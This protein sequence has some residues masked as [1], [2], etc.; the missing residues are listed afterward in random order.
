MAAA[1]VSKNR[2]GLRYPRLVVKLGTNLLTGGTDCLDTPTMAGLVSQVVRLVAAGHQV[3]VVSSGAIAAGREALAGRVPQRGAR[4]RGEVPLRQMLA[5]VGQSRLMQ[6][7][8]ELFVSHRVTVAQTLLTK[9]DLDDR[10]GYLNAR[11]T[12]LD[13]KSVV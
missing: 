6:R 9:A 2:A 12:L 4:T 7:Y 5:A 13:R 11:N 8:Q 1:G 3:V 10:A